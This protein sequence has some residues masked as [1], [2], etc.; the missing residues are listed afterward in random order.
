VGGQLSLLRSCGAAFLLL[1]ALALEQRPLQRSSF[2]ASHLQP[3]RSTT[4]PCMRCNSGSCP[5]PTLQTKLGRPSR[6]CRW[7]WPRGQVGLDGRR[8]SNALS[9]STLWGRASGSRCTGVEL[10]GPGAPRDGMRD[11]SKLTLGGR[12]VS[13]HSCIS[14]YARPLGKSVKD[15]MTPSPVT[16]RPSSNLDDVTGILLTRKIRRL[17]VVS[18]GGVVCG[19]QQRFS[20]AACCTNATA[21]PAAAAASF[22][23]SAPHLP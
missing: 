4:E 14:P 12:W 15:V 3:F 23:E 22:E 6:A 2:P 20:H 1:P 10:Q 19:N 8:V 7:R 16:V 9:A 18:P 11:A 5:P 21:L 13:L 17:P